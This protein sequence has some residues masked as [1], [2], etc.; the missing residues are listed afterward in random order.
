VLARGPQGRDILIA[1]AKS[2]RVYGL[3]PDDRGRILWMTELAPG[4]SHGAILWGLASEAQRSFVA[5]AGYDMT[6]GKGPGALVALDNTSGKVLWRTPAPALPCGWGSVNCSQAQIG[7]VSAIPGVVFS[8]AMDGRIRA[9]DSGTGA[10]LWEFDTGHE[11]P[12]VNGALA[13]GGA[14]DYGAQTIAYGMLFV[15]SG[16][17]RQPGNAL[18]AFSVDGQ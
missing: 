3:D 14:I 17:M 4:S 6:T 10:V 13:R 5:V 11:F 8:G 1:G 18:L 2:G 12:A 15:Q 7:A 16:S 9:Y